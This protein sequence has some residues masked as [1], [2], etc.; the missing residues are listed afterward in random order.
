MKTRTFNPRFRNLKYYLAEVF[1]SIFRNKIMSVSSIV[2]VASCVV[3]LIFAYVLGRNINFIINHLETTVGISVFIYNEIDEA[4]LPG[5][6]ARLLAI[7]GISDSYYISSE[8]ALLNLAERM[9]DYG[10]EVFLSLDIDNPLR[11]AFRLFLEDIREQEHIIPYLEDFSEIATVSSSADLTNFLLWVSNFA[12]IF[13]ISVIVILFILA[14]IIITNT[15]KLTVE[16]RRN[17]IFIMRYVGATAW[18]IKWPFVIEGIVIGVFGAIIPLG[19]LWIFYDGIV[20]SIVNT[21]MAFYILED[22]PFLA[23]SEVFPVFVPVVVLLGA[24][25]GFLGSLVSMRKH[26]SV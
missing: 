17:E 24:I 7:D 5:L 22:V 21:D 23:A 26:L 6:E 2:T 4:E 9:G 20:D 16:N 25:I 12:G 15:I 18:F 19:I 11:R 14:I 10:G 3:I 1:K 8:E 13:S